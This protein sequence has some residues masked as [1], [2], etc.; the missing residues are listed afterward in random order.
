MD[1]KGRSRFQLAEFGAVAHKRTGDKGHIRGTASKIDRYL[2]RSHLSNKYFNFFFGNCAKIY[3]TMLI[4]DLE[5]T[6]E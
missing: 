5:L 3:R 6:H 2:I 1:I 4:T